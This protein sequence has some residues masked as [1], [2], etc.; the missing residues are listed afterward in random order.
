MS[1]LIEA[2]SKPPA[3]NRMQCSYRQ[4]V[5]D[6]DADERKAL[7]TA[8]ARCRSTDRQDRHYSFRWLARVISETGARMSDYTIRRHMRGDCSCDESSR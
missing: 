7:D 5:Q 3:E 2:L 1:K 4:F 8:V 6:L